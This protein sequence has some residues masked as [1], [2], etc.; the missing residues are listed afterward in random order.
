MTSARPRPTAA[1]ALRARMR[2]T[3]PAVRAATSAL[4]CAPGLARRYP[5]YL[6]LMHGVVRASVPLMERAAARCAL[7]RDPVAGPLAR[8][9]AAHIEEERGHD[10]WLAADLAAL[11][12]DPARALG[13]PP[14]PAV[15]SLVG[16]QYYWIE[17]HHPVALLGYIAVLEGNAPAPWLA[18]RV[19]RSAGVPATALRTVRAHADLDTGH[20]DALYALLDGLDLTP[21]QVDAVTTSAL[22]TVDALLRLFGTLTRTPRPGGPHGFP[23]TA[24]GTS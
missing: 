12:H 24:G 15:A 23:G 19:V 21:G 10:A 14:P 9:L 16:A 4:W 1:E 20:S 11:G 13:R 6:R 3:E 18:D 22:F 8:Y 5:Q 7:L 17:H 2:L